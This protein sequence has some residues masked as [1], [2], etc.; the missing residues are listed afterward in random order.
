MCLPLPGVAKASGV[1][2]SASNVPN[3][4]A[5]EYGNYVIR[6]VNNWMQLNKSEFCATACPSFLA[7]F[8]VPTTV[9]AVCGARFE[10]SQFTAGEI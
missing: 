8:P 4:V 1:G 7:N 6:P 3:L 10:G 2:T 5:D 9:P